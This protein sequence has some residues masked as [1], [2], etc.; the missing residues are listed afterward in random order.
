ML[1]IGT[2]VDFLTIE[3]AKAMGIAI[4]GRQ[5]D[6][7][8]DVRYPVVTF[9]PTRTQAP[10]YELDLIVRME[11]SVL[12]ANGHIEAARKQVPLVVAWVI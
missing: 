2:V 8:P 7:E 6:A 3:E 11:T 5:V 9:V 4:S 1:T 10:Q 12:N